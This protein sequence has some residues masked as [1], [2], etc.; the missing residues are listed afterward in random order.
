MLVYKAVSHVDA[1]YPVS[2]T[3]YA[4]LHSYRLLFQLTYNLQL[5]LILG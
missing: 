2:E 4:L 1:Y 5:G 3:L